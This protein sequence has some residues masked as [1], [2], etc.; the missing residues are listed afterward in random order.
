MYGVARIAQFH[1]NTVFSQEEVC[2]DGSMDEEELARI[3]ESLGAEA[4]HFWEQFLREAETASQELL[5]SLQEQM[6]SAEMQ[7]F[8]TRLAHG[9]LP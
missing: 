5:R 9:D 6:E 3:L 8:L 4:D 7:D 2:Y 1:G